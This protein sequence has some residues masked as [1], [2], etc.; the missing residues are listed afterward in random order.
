VTLETDSRLVEGLESNAPEGT[1]FGTLYRNTLHR[2]GPYTYPLYTV[3]VCPWVYKLE[4]DLQCLMEDSAPSPP[5]LARKTP[6]CRVHRC[7]THL[8]RKA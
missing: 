6:L 1:Y 5:P 3:R 4:H 8:A 7:V 2:D